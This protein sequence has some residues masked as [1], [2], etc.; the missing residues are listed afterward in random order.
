I[1]LCFITS[2]LHS[3]FLKRTPFLFQQGYNKSQFILLPYMMGENPHAHILRLFIEDKNG[4]QKNSLEERK[5][6]PIFSR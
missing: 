6:Y 5:R 3:V 2:D 4:E 1:C